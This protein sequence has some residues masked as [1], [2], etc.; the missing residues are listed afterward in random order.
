M[1]LAAAVVWSSLLGMSGCRNCDPPVDPDAEIVIEGTVVIDEGE[2]L[3]DRLVYLHR[4][5]TI[6]EWLTVATGGG[7]GLVADCIVNNNE[8]DDGCG[9]FRV[10]TTDSDG[11][12]VFRLRGDD[13][14]N[15]LNEP[16]RFSVSAASGTGSGNGTSTV[17][18]EVH[19][20]QLAFPALS[21]WQRAPAA[22]VADGIVN[23]SWREEPVLGDTL[24]AETAFFFSQRLDGNDG[25]LWRHTTTNTAALS[26][27]AR[28]FQDVEVA[29]GSRDGVSLFLF[30]TMVEAIRHPPRGSFAN[31]AEAPRSRGAACRYANAL[32]E[33]LLSPCPLTDGDFGTRFE[34][35]EPVCEEMAPPT[36]GGVTDGGTASEGRCREAAFEEVTVDLGQATTMSVLFLHAVLPATG[37][38]VSVGQD[39][40]SF[41]PVLTDAAAYSINDLDDQS[42]QF[43]RFRREV[44]PGARSLPLL[45]VNE[46]GAY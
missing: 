7:P 36:D 12:Y 44:E 29:F 20:E 25:W 34:N 46:I 3:A 13:T 45:M 39:G 2:P 21:L 10:D 5:L 43:L 28:I 23:F 16:A 27:D 9:A 35:E 17:Q 15:L 30:S 24:A 32:G 11:R 38:T 1:R 41:E 26:L 18:F 42:V 33:H 37:V 22:S 8:A 31:A 6:D 14:F 19:T 40:E 4:A